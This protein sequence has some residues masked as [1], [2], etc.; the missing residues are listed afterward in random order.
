MLGLASKGIAQGRRGAG[1]PGAE[2]PL[3]VGVRAVGQLRAWGRH[4]RSGLQAHSTCALLQ[5]TL[6]PDRAGHCQLRD[7]PG[8]RLHH[9]QVRGSSGVFP[10]GPLLSSAPIPGITLLAWLRGRAG[11]VPALGGDMAPAVAAFPW[12]PSRTVLPAPRTVLV[13]QRR[14]SQPERQ[15]WHHTTPGCKLQH[16]PP[17]LQTGTPGTG[18]V[19]GGRA[20]AAQ[21][22]C[23]GCCPGQRA[24]PHAR[25][26][27]PRPEGQGCVL[28]SLALNLGP[29]S[30]G[31]QL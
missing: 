6:V 2:G 7:L 18:G 27:S 31:G 17:C 9:L 15:S 23:R 8:L 1:I 26:S 22:R 4:R 29:L 11:Q 14:L 16:L 21:C 13:C 24:C 5:A 19:L 20:A 28:V 25:L 10:V 30:L 3:L 12:P